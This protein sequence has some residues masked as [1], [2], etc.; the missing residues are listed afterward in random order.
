MA[1]AAPVIL[2]GNRMRKKLLP[3]AIAACALVGLAAT[4][5]GAST[6]PREYV[7]VYEQGASG[8]TARAAITDAGGKIVSEN[9]EIGVATVRSTDGAFAGDVARSG[10][11]VG[12]TTNRAIGRA[13]RDAGQARQDREGRRLAARLGLQGPPPAR[14]RP[15]RRGAVGHADDPRDGEGLVRAPAGLEGRARRHHRHRRRRRPSRHQ[16]ELQRA[17]EPQLHGRRPVDRRR[18]RHRSGPARAR[19]RPTSTRTATART[20]PRRSARR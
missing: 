18:L 14:R 6:A 2:G 5:D 3:A 15:A 9:A 11:I 7:V 16:A 12:A 17:P 1:G 20:W 10:A 4:A 19:T 8:K 13:P